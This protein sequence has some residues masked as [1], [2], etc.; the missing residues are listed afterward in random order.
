MIFIPLMLL[1]LNTIKTNSVTHR[2]TATS[3]DSESFEDCEGKLAIII[4]D[5]G[6][7]RSGV[8]EIMTIDRHLT[9][10]V[11]PFL[12][13]SK[14]DAETAHEKGFEVI[15]HLSMEPNYGKPS[16]LGPRPILF[17]MNTEDVKKI[18]YDAFEDVPYSVGANIHMG[19]KASSDATIVSSILDIV[20]EKMY[21]FVDSKTA[22]SPICKKIAD[23]IGVLCY[24]RDIFI[25]ER[26]SEEG[27]KTQLQKAIEIA[28]KK[29]K[30]VAIGHI[31]PE[32]GIATANAIREMLPEFDAKKV[33][34]VFISELNEE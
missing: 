22:S 33:K 10:A 2:D 34:L 27:I 11:M 3:T 18:V 13:F 25:D 28:L 17:G 8:K 19:S 29:K 5:F 6:Q 16:W 21:Y 23:K 1:M 26:R 4:D 30:A 15:V 7:S 24:D 9:F 12:E 14:T 31:G 20:K 32:G